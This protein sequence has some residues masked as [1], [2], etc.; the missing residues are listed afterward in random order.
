MF[1]LMGQINDGGIT[2]T[3]IL[4]GMHTTDYSSSLQWQF[5]GNGQN[6]LFIILTHTRSGN[7]IVTQWFPNFLEGI[8]LRAR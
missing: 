2:P 4:L 3:C 7:A 6:P 5:S 8:P 1:S